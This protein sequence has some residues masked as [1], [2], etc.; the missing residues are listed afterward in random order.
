[1]LLIPLIRLKNG[2]S[3][4]RLRDDLTIPKIV[5]NVPEE[6]A[7]IFRGENFKA[8]HISILDN[9]TEGL[10]KSNLAVQKI[11]NTIDIPVQISSMIN[12]PG[13]VEF[14]LKMGCYR[15]IL[16]I[17]DYNC[18]DFIKNIIKEFSAN[19]IVVK[20]NSYAGDVYNCLWD[21]ITPFGEIPLALKLKEIGVKRFQ[22]SC[23]IDMK[24]KTGI[25]FGRI[26]KF[27]DHVGLKLSL[28]GG[29]RNIHDL[30]NLLSLE[31]YGVDSLILGRSLYQNCFCCEHLWRKNEEL[32]DNLGPTRR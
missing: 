13:D 9:D 19:K 6:L 21:R 10:E 12:K 25:D 2:F 18:F 15:V 16:H 32:L 4:M 20:I 23:F 24:S 7:T 28:M 14:Y 17:K 29:I 3:Q 11:I 22:Y 27:A 31:R 1:M 30:K 8:L 5:T 26:E